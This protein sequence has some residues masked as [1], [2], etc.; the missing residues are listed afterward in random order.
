MGRF[1]DWPSSE[2]AVL[3]FRRGFPLREF[4][5]DCALFSDF[6]EATPRFSFRHFADLFV[7]L[8]PL[9]GLIEG[10]GP[11][12]EKCAKWASLCGLLWM[13][14]GGPPGEPLFFG[15]SPNEERVAEIVEVFQRRWGAEAAAW[16][17]N[18]CR[19][20]A[21]RRA[22]QRVPGSPLPSFENS[23]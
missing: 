15:R 17:N 13:D 16:V 7:R 19:W 22:G 10:Q 1:Q 23:R 3:P 12:E 6:P 20:P 2:W 14:L 9:Q 21:T 11:D 4:L 8:F 5:A 18:A